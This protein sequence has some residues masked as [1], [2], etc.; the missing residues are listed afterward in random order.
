[1]SLYKM[2]ISDKTMGAAQGSDPEVQKMMLDAQQNNNQTIS[3]PVNKPGFFERLLNY[4]FGAGAAEPDILNRKSVITGEFPQNQFPFRSMAEMAAANELALNNMY[5][6]PNI[7]FDANTFDDVTTSGELP[8]VMSP[9]INYL[10]SQNFPK[11]EFGGTVLEDDN[12]GITQ[13]AAAQKFE[14]P[15][16]IIGGQKVYLDD[17]LGTAQALEKADFFQK[18][19]GS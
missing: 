13:S 14:P 3:E 7:L 8:I 16:Q 19:T 9:K 18:P 11:I 17:K 5:T 2:G 15:F 6:T 10:D 4:A 12:T 1:M